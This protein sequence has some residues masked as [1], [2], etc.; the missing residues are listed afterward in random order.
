[1]SYTF[2]SLT[3]LC[4][5][6]FLFA[7]GEN[8]LCSDNPSDENCK[9]KLHTV[10]IFNTRRRGSFRPIDPI[11]EVLNLSNHALTRLLSGRN[12]QLFDTT[13]H[14]PNLYKT[15]ESFTYTT[16]YNRDEV[17]YI[18]LYGVTDLI[19]SNNNVTVETLMTIL[20]D[21]RIG[22]D[23]QTHPLKYLDLS[24]LNISWLPSSIFGQ[25]STLR[26]LKLNNN[27]IGDIGNVENA[28]GSLRNSLR[29]LDLSGCGLKFLPDVFPGFLLTKL[30][31]NNNLL[32]TVPKL[33][34]ILQS[35]LKLS[36]DGNPLSV[37][38]DKSF[39][40]YYNIEEISADNC[41]IHT[42][43]GETFSQ[44]VRLSR[45]NLRNNN[46]RYLFPT[47]IPLKHT[48]VTLENN[49]WD[50]TCRNLWLM[51][52]THNQFGSLV[53][54]YSL[55]CSTPSLYAN[56]P[57]YEVARSIENLDNCD[58]L[59]FNLLRKPL[60]PPPP[61]S[62]LF[63]SFI[64]KKAMANLFISFGLLAIIATVAAVVLIRKFNY[65]SRQQIYKP[66]YNILEQEQEP[67]Y[68]DE[69]VIQHM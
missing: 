55:R 48:I 39:R 42:I 26:V 24:C 23:S 20:R 21:Q 35:L 37:L 56:R 49:P 59:F 36:I 25:F 38:D 60:P 53:N 5:S 7:S 67:G 50:C 2:W 19:L 52:E 45:L 3:L 68:L 54:S 15:A 12:H 41:S 16:P 51:K 28:I 8:I 63:S 22:E 31:L 44:N 30:S 65:K 57:L 13:T 14:Y 69:K 33:Y 32:T 34:F 62:H 66:L 47:D 58:S 4:T 17:P 43:T 61:H 18:N 11:N 29:E 64:S 27:P 1:M 40:M 46:I 10:N 9:R 6:L